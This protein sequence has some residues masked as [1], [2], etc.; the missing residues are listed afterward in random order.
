VASRTFL[1]EPALLSKLVVKFHGCITLQRHGIKKHCKKCRRKKKRRS[2]C[3][4][5]KIT[6]SAI[7]E[8]KATKEAHIDVLPVTVG[9]MLNVA[10]ALVTVN[11]GPVF[12]EEHIGQSSWTLRGVGNTSLDPGVA[13]NMTSEPQYSACWNTSVRTFSSVTSVT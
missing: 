1:T 7:I 13:T 6:T 10:S 5:G 4:C 12:L 11:P 2:S 8:K 3:V 9:E